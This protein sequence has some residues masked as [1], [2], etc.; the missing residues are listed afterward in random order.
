MFLFTFINLGAFLLSVK[1]NKS[2]TK[3][4]PVIKYLGSKFNVVIYK[5][6]D[7]H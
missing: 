2:S 7:L 5:K 3:S 1:N 6:I 4:T